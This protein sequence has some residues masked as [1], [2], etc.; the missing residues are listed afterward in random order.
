M[1]A[2]EST[3]SV[4]CTHTLMNAALVE[5]EVRIV[6]KYVVLVYYNLTDNLGR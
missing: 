2:D 5:D 6:E 1:S 4:A 3:S